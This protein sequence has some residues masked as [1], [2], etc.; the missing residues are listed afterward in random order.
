MV[1]G[2]LERHGGSIA[3]ESAPG[4]GTTFSLSFRASNIV[5]ARENPSIDSS[6]VV[7]LRVL[8]V[9]DEPALG[10]MLAQLL[11]V[12]GHQVVVATSGEEALGLFSRS[13]EPF[14]LIVSDV[15]MGAG[16]NGWELAR[17]TLA[18]YPST[19]FALV[20]RSGGADR[21]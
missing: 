12:D 6:P 18:H 4:R 7:P 8:V 1:L 2:V 10:R 19:C 3:L 15:G 13:S 11:H 9:D 14:D 20:D 17:Q 21:R 16:M 5:A